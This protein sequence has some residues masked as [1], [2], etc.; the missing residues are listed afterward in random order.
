MQPADGSRPWLLAA[1]ALGALGVALGAFG[2][3]ALHR[4]LPL[5]LMT[6][7]ETGVRYHLL[8][9]LALLACAMLLGR[10]PQRGRRL[11][12]AAWGFLAGIV[13][14]S[15][16]LYGLALTGWGWLGLLTPLGGLAWIAA[17][18]LLAAAFLPRDAA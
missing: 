14:F 4:W 3:H 10:Y 17:W 2:A 9:T 8:H 11:R 15:G 12:G 18:L 5:Q 13:A 6:I 16:S 7:Y 1:G